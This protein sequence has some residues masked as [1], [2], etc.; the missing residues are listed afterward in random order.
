MV[1]LGAD[2]VSS[3]RAGV[4]VGVGVGAV[5][6]A[7]FMVLL[8]SDTRGDLVAASDKRCMVSRRLSALTSA[9]RLRLL[10]RG[11]E[12]LGRDFEVFDRDSR[13][14]IKTT[15]GRVPGSMMVTSFAT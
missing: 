9:E 11:R 10:S 1:A 2:C 12:W 8:F 15:V 4:V 5:L 7:C 3:S 13:A 14:L 6:G